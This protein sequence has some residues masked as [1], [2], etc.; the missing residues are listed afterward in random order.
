VKRIQRHRQ[1]SRE[2]A[3]LDV[4]PFMNLMIV[5]VPVLLLSMVFT[6]TAVIELNFPSSDGAA[7]AFDS[8]SV[9]LEV[10][11]Y[12]D[13]LIVADGRG[14]TIKEIANKT[15]VHDFAA[16]SVVMQELKKRMPK[17]EDVT[18][19][20]QEETD[21]QTLVTVMDKVRSYPAVLGLEVVDAALFPVISL[22]DTP[23]APNAAVSSVETTP[24]RLKKE[25]G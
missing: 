20:L 5:L 24:A 23:K 21:Y 17:K 19:L 25:S 22:G 2:A 4:T 11:V 18:V 12:A 8:E 3:E 13:R 15:G 16:L 14:G 10:Q 1:R 7:S 6:H 9:H